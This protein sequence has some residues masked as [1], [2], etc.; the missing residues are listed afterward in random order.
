MRKA[1]DVKAELLEASADLEAYAQTESAELDQL[2]SMKAKADKLEAEYAQSV[3]FEKIRAEVIARKEN[4]AKAAVQPPAEPVSE[5]VKKE[6]VNVI[7]AKVKAQRSKHFAS[8]EDAFTAGMYLAHLGG[9]QRAGEIL[10]AQSVGTDNKGGFSVPD[11]LSNALINLLE[12]YG[13]AR[14]YC[15]RIVMSALTWSVPKVTAHAAVSYPDEAAPISETEVAFGQVLLTAKK[16]AALV[17]MSTEIQEDSVI[18]MMD[19]VV[20]S[21]AYSI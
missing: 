21:L 11:P 13:V 8:S 9:D 7:P 19:T 18:S 4:E 3:E 15:R 14:R 16:I 2:N 6:I 5:P 12:D 10:A 17:K 1:V 20:Q